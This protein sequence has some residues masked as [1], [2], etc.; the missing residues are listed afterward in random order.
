[1]LWRTIHERHNTGKGLWVLIGTLLLLSLLAGANFEGTRKMYVAGQVADHDVE[2]DRDLLVED[3]QAT[4]ARRKQVEMLQPPVYDLSMDAFAAFQHRLIAVFQQLNTSS[5]EA[6]ADSPVRNLSNDLPPPVAD[7]VMPYLA[8]PEIQTVIISTLFPLI[9]DRMAEGLVG[10]VRT[11]RVG[12][13]GAIIRN[14]DN[15]T[16][17]LRPDIVALPDLPSFLAEISGK[18]QQTPGLSDSA[19]RAINNLMISSLSASLTLNREA[20]QKR[21]AAV[22]QNV[23]PVYYQLQKGEL[24][25]RKGERVSREQQIK[26][27]SLYATASDPIRWNV[28]AGAFI[29]S[30]VLSI[31]FF[32][33]PSGKP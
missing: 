28:V 18:L 22:V 24:I 7:E 2:A 33:S 27:Q 19:R 11:S 20:T 5:G 29:I 25:V 14:L 26:L 13:S 6:L 3:T 31:G 32:A 21:A 4:K 8:Q 9:R 12:R 15:G 10:D 16:E 23:E 1:M 17:L 30:L